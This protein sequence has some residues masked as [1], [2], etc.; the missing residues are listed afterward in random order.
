ME[1]PEVMRCMSEVVEGRICLWEVLEVL[2][3]I[4]CVLL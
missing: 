1:V 4:H 2:E 3:T